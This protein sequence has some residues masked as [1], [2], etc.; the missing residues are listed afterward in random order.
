MF[1]MVCI[2]ELN[3]TSTAWALLLLLGSKHK[4]ALSYEFRCGEPQR[5]INVPWIGY[6]MPSYCPQSLKTSHE[7]RD[8][9]TLSQVFAQSADSLGVPHVRFEEFCI[10]WTIPTE[11]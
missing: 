6:G 10:V 2:D 11:N 1:R 5:S 9:H 8:I 7:S 4:Q 3:F